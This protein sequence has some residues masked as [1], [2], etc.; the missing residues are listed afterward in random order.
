[1]E[2][3]VVDPFER[4]ARIPRKGAVSLVL[5]DGDPEVLLVPPLPERVVLEMNDEDSSGAPGARLRVIRLQAV[6]PDQSAEGLAGMLRR[7]ADGLDPGSS[8][9]SPGVEVEGPNVRLILGPEIPP[10]TPA[11]VT[12][13]VLNRAD[14]EI[15]SHELR[16]PINALVGYAAL[17]DDAIFGDLTDEQ[18]KA[19]MNM[20]ESA[21]RLLVAL[22]HLFQMTR[23]DLG[24]FEERAGLTAQTVGADES[25]SGA[26]DPAG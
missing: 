7:L 6:D 10:E 11:G 3:T 23:V 2:F 5:K 1:M 20:R 4:Q 12:P 26:A 8:T 9:K 17:L 25:P 16:T 15:I 18:A 24:H 22:R 21:E 13:E 19:V 14:L